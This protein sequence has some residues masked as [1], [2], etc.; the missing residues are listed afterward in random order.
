MKRL[1]VPIYGPGIAEEVFKTMRREFVSRGVEIER[2][3]FRVD[4]GCWVITFEGHEPNGDR[5]S[6]SRAEPYTP[7]EAPK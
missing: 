6:L 7:Q 5:L 1:L 4:S 3:S 2:I